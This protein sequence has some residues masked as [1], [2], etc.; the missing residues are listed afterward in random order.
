MED[1]T[2]GNIVKGEVTGI[3]PYGIFIKINDDIDGL[4]H[5]SEIANKFTVIT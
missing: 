4:I 2:V 3:E 1:Y 5:I